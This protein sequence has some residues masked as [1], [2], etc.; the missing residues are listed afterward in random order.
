QYGSLDAI[1]AHAGEVTAKR[2]REALLAHADDARLSRELV[3]I[4]TD[5]PVPVALDALV[6]GEPD[7]ARVLKLLTELEFFSL[8]RRLGTGAGASPPPAPV[9]GEGA[10]ELTEGG[11]GPPAAPSAALRDS[12][13]SSAMNV[14][15]LDDPAGLAPVIERLR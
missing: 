3:T 12:S 1:L 10:E 2:Q 11:E 15:I 6:E 8:A 5:V 14:T 4:H 13:A 7:Q 9:N